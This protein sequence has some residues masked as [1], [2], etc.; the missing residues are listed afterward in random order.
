MASFVEKRGNET[1][2]RSPDTMEVPSLDLL[3]FLLDNP[4]NERLKKDTILHVDAANPSRNV[5]TAE[6]ISHLQ[7]LAH[8]LR[9]KYGIREGDV[10]QAIFTGH[11]L[12]PSVFLGIIAAGATVACALPSF[13]QEEIAAQAVRAESKLLICNPDLK[14]LAGTVGSLAGLPDD[15]I[16]Y[17]GDSEDLELYEVKSDTRIPISSDEHP[18]TRITDKKT[19]EKTTTCIVYTG[20]TTGTPK[21]IP[22]S[23]ANIVASVYLLMEPYRLDLGMEF[24]TVAHA[25]TGHLVG[26]LTYIVAQ[27]FLGGTVFWMTRF[28]FPQLMG[29]CKQYSVTNIM[30]PPPVWLVITKAPFVT[31]QLDSVR[32]AYSSAAPMGADVQNAAERKLGKGR[33]LLSQVWGMSEASGPITAPVK[34]ERDSTGSLCVLLANSEMRIVDEEGRDVEPGTAGE[35]WVRGPQVVSGYFKN[36]KAGRESFV[37]GW[38]RTGDLIYFRDGKFY[39]VDRAKEIIKFRGKKVIPAQLESVLVTH[40]LIQDAGVIGVKVDG[41]EVPRAYVVADESKVSGKDIQSWLADQA[42]E[43]EQQLRGGVVFI[44]AVPRSPPGKILREGLRTLYLAHAAS[45]L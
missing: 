9:T 17:F 29:Y 39:F 10:V 30:C 20:G 5:T 18:W 40:P 7:R 35:A 32:L 26:I 3:S 23:H 36:E 16:L 11:I 14:E 13:S 2:Y 33:G 41:D 43:D 21:A 34:G 19:L 42:T 45:S 22:I 37:D 44:E 25:P 12:C 1:I 38:Y 31:D 6:Q 8:T 27:A 4:Q 15:R 24:R 28:D